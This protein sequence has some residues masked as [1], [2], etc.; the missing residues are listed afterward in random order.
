MNSHPPVQE[1]YKSSR[2]SKANDCVEVFQGDAGVGVR[3]SKHPGG[4]ELWFT[5]AAWDAFL[6]SDIWHD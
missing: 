3:D 6:D 5:G 2:S 4:P 1:W